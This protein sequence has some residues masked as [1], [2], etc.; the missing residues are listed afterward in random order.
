MIINRPSTETWRLCPIWDDFYSKWQL[1]KLWA[2]TL[3]VVKWGVSVRLETQNLMEVFSRAC[4]GSQHAWDCQKRTARRYF[5]AVKPKRILN[6]YCCNKGLRLLDS[7]QHSSLRSTV[8][9]QSISLTVFVEGGDWEGSSKAT[10]EN[11]TRN[12]WLLQPALY[13][14][15]YCDLIVVQTQLDF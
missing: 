11:Q 8:S 4:L 5:M 9:S 15:S 14:L 1:W 12:L 7:S 6:A 10:T 13:Q 2:V 3:S